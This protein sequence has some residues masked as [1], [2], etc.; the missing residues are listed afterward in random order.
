MTE[1]PSKGSNTAIN[2]VEVSS[3]IDTKI[4]SVSL[5]SGLAEVTRVFKA[6]LKGGDNKVVILSLP[7]VFIAESQRCEWYYYTIHYYWLWTFRV[8]GHGPCTIHEVSISEIPRRAPQ[9]T[10]PQF[11][12]LL[13]DKERIGKAIARCQTCIASVE[14]YQESL[15]VQYTP[16]EQLWSIGQGVETVASDLDKNLI[17]LEEKVATVTKH[18]QD[19]REALGEVKEDDKLQ[20]RVSVT[21]AADKECEVEFVLIYGLFSIFVFERGNVWPSGTWLPGVR[22]ATWDAAYDIYVKMDAKDK[23]VAL[24]Y[25]GAILQDTAEVRCI[26]ND[27]EDTHKRCSSSTAMGWCFLN[28]R[29]SNASDGTHYSEVGTMDPLRISPAT[30]LSSSH[31]RTHPAI[32]KDF[33]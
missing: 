19:E 29:D 4:T 30:R 13:R 1:I 20:Q 31:E 15:N 12:S 14:K 10:S 2:V 28:T 22:N 21:V 8:E 3:K 9:K 25:K 18:I 16:A 6:N 11:T 26:S 33:C 32:Q 23:P 17:E 5:Y 7:N 24:I 27:E